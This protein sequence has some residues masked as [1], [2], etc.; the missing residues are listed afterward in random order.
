MPEPTVPPSNPAAPLTF[1]DDH[2]P[3]LQRSVA[4]NL[5]NAGVKVPYEAV[6]PSHVP[7]EK[8]GNIIDEKKIQTERSVPESFNSTPETAL[9]P[10]K[11]LSE[12]LDYADQLVTGR[13]HVVG[14][15]QPFAG[16]KKEK[17]DKRMQFAN[18]PQKNQKGPVK[19]FVD[20]L[21]H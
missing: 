21:H 7:D 2:L 20:W 9:S 12:H 4:S 18:T 11:T 15:A 3:A 8:P 10:L 16:F 19:K 1:T 17:E 13:S 5:Q 6:K 14:D